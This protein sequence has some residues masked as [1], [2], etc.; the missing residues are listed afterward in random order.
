MCDVSI[1]A[2]L[3]HAVPDFKAAVISYHHIVISDIP[4]IIS[5]RLPLYY[6][7]IRLSLE[8]HPI[9][10]IPGVSE[11]RAVFKKVGTDPSRYRP[12]QESLLRKIKRDGQPHRIH[13]AA[14][15]NNFFSVQYSIPLGIYDLDVLKPP[16][17]LKIGGP[18][19]QYSGLNGRVMHMDD[20]IVSADSAGAFGSPIVD[21]KRTC[22]T[23]S[24]QNALQ[25]IYLRPSMSDAEARK[26][27]AKTAEM[28][29][30][31]HG[32]ENKWQIIN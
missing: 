22:V 1:S 15:L 13:S 29:T 12:S 11:W 2:A 28:F 8:T 31:V 25:I 20:K 30:Q 21:S 24:T 17:Q 3:K 23:K 4:P 7:N 6:E 18:E 14:D 26:L 32:G 27:A 9:H 5:E 19:D 10:E 16:V